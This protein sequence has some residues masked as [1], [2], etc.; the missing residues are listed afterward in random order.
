MCAKKCAQN[1]LKHGKLAKTL[2]DCVKNMKIVPV[3]PVLSSKSKFC[4][5]SRKF[6]AVVRLHDF[7]F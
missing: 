6:C 5:D 7:S 1:A 3:L 2:S 4:A